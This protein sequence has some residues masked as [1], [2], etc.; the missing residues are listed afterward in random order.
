MK[1]VVNNV[2]HPDMEMM[3]W[4]VY[5]GAP[6]DDI[7]VCSRWLDR[8]IQFFHLIFPDEPRLQ[9][10]NNIDEAR[11]YL[12]ENLLKKGIE[13]RS[14]TFVYYNN[15]ILELLNIQDE[16]MPP[17]LRVGAVVACYAQSKIPYTWTSWWTFDADID[18]TINAVMESMQTHLS[19]GRKGYSAFLTA[20]NNYVISKNSGV[21]V[22]GI[23]KTIVSLIDM[24][25]VFFHFQSLK[26]S[27][28]TYISFLRLL[29][30]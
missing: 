20:V 16:A 23:E 19:Q 29:R 8:V 2:E 7:A 3:F 13:K 11:K 24:L 1:R 15:V 25:E 21:S 17:L 27:R 26:I 18:A 5:S 10:L 6:S 22:S 30:R 12:S 9:R 14:P 28:L 4:I